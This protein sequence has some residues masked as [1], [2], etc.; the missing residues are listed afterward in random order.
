MHEKDRRP[1]SSVLWPSAD[2][3]H[4]CTA[5]HPSASWPCIWRQGSFLHVDRHTKRGG[6]SGHGH[7]IRSTAT[8]RD[9]PSRYT[10]HTK[11]QTSWVGVWSEMLIRKYIC[12]VVLRLYKSQSNMWVV[13]RLDWC[14]VKKATR[15][16]S[17]GYGG[18]RSKVKEGVQLVVLATQRHKSFVNS[19]ANSW[20]WD[21]DSTNTNI[22]N[23]KTY[24]WLYISKQ[25]YNCQQIYVTH[26]H[27]HMFQVTLNKHS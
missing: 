13:L 7:M 18:Q 2:I 4:V 23:N 17:R 22:N 11:W 3:G 27:S 10:R 16:V 24:K 6:T 9:S 19:L 20:W 26:T 25:T 15:R 8:C 1:C 12:K 14:Y 21:S 5:W